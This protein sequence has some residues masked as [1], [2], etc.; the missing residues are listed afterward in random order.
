MS[1][2]LAGVFDR[3]IGFDVSPDQLELARA[4]VAGE[5]AEAEFRL[6]AGAALGSADGEADAVFSTH[7]FQ[8]LP[9]RLAGALLVDCGR[10]L[11]EGGTAM[12]HLPIP[13]TNLAGTHFGDVLRRLR[14]MAPVRAA[15]LRLG[16]R[17]GRTVPPMRFQVFD[18]AWVF[19]RLERGGLAEVE[20][21][22]FDVG[23]MRLAFFL[24]RKPA[25]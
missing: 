14:G 16:H 22:A 2:Q 3:L 18:P 21:H 25:A 24:A 23:G 20:L 1:R 6:S 11:A 5:R 4:A 7:V 15:G 13:G 12:L 19:E 17:L 8:H 10:V 9:P